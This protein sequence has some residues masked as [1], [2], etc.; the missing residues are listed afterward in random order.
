MNCR[1]LLICALFAG[2]ACTAQAASPQKP[3]ADYSAKVSAAVRPHIV[4][5]E[6]I[7]NPSTV[8]EVHTDPDG[9]ITSRRITQSSG[10]VV[11]D[12]AVLRALNKTGKLP[13]DQGI[14]HSPLLIEFR[15]KE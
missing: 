5:D 4:L 6:D 1:D 7:G 11:Y 3:S 2:V 9:T 12:Q 10:H 13:S 8:V 15:P 14:F